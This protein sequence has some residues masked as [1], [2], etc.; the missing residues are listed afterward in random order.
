MERAIKILENSRQDLEMKLWWA[1]E[2]DREPEFA[3]QVP[4]LK[5]D[6]EHI[7]QALAVLQEFTQPPVMI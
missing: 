2:H 5:N 7:K 6:I 3:V 4:E 1:E